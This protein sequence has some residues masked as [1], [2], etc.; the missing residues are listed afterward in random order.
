MMY[1][2]KQFMLTIF[3]QEKLIVVE[4]RVSHMQAYI[5]NTYLSRICLKHD[6]KKKLMFSYKYLQW[7]SYVYNEIKEYEK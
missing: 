4:D 3:F 5:I 1:K 2:A 6:K 7:C